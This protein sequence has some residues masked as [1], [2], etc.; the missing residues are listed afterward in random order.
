MK[1]LPLTEQGRC[2]ARLNSIETD[3]NIWP[4]TMNYSK[5]GTN[6]L[7]RKCMNY[8]FYF[9]TVHWNL[10]FTHVEN[11]KIVVHA[12]KLTTVCCLIKPAITNLYITSKTQNPEG[13][14]HV[15]EHVLNHIQ[16]Q[17]F[18]Y[19]HCHLD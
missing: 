11:L 16:Q 14:L 6:R 12:L 19:I 15:K 9:H 13:L 17:L 8:F 18:Q 5:L 7:P 10:F 1:S 3:I 2:L 4:I